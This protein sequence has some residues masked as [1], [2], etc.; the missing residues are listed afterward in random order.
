MSV[1]SSETNKF[2]LNTSKWYGRTPVIRDI[3]KYIMVGCTPRSTFGEQDFAVEYENEYEK[4]IELQR[5]DSMSEKTS[6]SASENTENPKKDVGGT[7]FS[8]AFGIFFSC[9]G[10]VIGSGNI[11]RFPRIVAQ[12]SFD[13]G[14]LAFLIVWIISLFLWSIPI[15]IIEFT[16][17]RFTKSGPLVSFTKFFGQKLAFIG[18]WT[19]FVPFLISCYYNVIVGWCFYYVYYSCAATELPKDQPESVKVFD[20]FTQGSKYPVLCHTISLAL[21]TICVF[22]GLKWIEWVNSTLVTLLAIIILVTFGWALSLDHADIGLQYLFTPSWSSLANA[23][24]WIQAFIQNAFDTGAGLGHYAVY[25]AFFKRTDSSVIYAI[26]LPMLNNLV[27]LI[28]AMS[29]FS[30]VFATMISTRP[31]LTITAIQNLMKESGPGST[32]LTFTWIPVLYQTMGIAGRVL[33]GLFFICLSF[34]GLTTQISNIQLTTVTLK[35]CGV[36]HYIATTISVII[37]FLLGVPAALDIHYLTNQDFVWGFALII[38]G[39][40]YCV[41]PMYYGTERYRRKIVNEFGIGDWYLYPIWTFLVIFL[42]PI[43]AAVFIVWWAIGLLQ[44][45]N[46][47]SLGETSF[48][49]TIIEWCALLVV[50]LI[51]NLILVKCN[52]NILNRDDSDGYDPYHLE[53]VPYKEDDHGLVI[54][55]QEKDVEPMDIF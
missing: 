6:Y 30:T 8:T 28:C 24:L 13:Q 52:I 15:I 14:S 37:T 4:S 21:V 9:V 16:I 35:N 1:T 41:L 48:F 54:E 42:I 20:D 55:V 27:S 23:E 26:T 31:T 51:L 11:W 3:Y 47:N 36:S 39:L 19:V 17:G 46:W 53:L 45:P 5:K 25:S 40:L 18:G 22:G 38:S 7:E 32:G 33:C 43:L 12:N 44:G 50:L 34:A 10:S 29:I 49:L 2:P